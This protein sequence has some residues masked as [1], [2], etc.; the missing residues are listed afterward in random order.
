[1]DGPAGAHTSIKPV[2]G[3]QCVFYWESDAF[4]VCEFVGIKVLSPVGNARRDRVFCARAIVDILEEP[5][6][7]KPMETPTGKI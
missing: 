4:G 3:C 7:L 6:R 2:R 5:A 1:M